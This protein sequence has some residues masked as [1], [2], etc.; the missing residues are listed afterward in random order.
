MKKKLPLLLI[1]CLISAISFAQ[2]SVGQTSDF[3][4]GT[5][6]GWRHQNSNPN[7]PVNITTD[8]PA[9]TDDNYVQ[10]TSSGANGAG[11]RFAIINT[12]A[13]WLGDYIAAGVVAISFDVRNP[14]SSDL[15]LRVAAN[16]VSFGQWISTSNAVVIPA[17]SDW[18]SVTI[19]IQ[20]SD[21]EKSPGGNP[22]LT[23]ADILSDVDQIRIVSNDGSDPTAFSSYLHKGDQVALEGDFDNITADDTLSDEDFFVQ[24]EGFTISPNP[25]KN[26]LNISLPQSLESAMINVYDV[27]GK[28]VYTGQI[29]SLKPSIDVSNWNSG[30]YLVRVSNDNVT[31]TKRF[32][33]Q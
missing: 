11:S 32:V 23:V 20:A 1:S 12:E 2:I 16:G 18:T 26:D 21:M 31:H 24:D 5:T 10:N 6:Q 30:V 15:Y 19:N 4:D 33:K 7:D 14:G 28:R 29:N 3:E 27:L 9:G 13:D 25:G 17:G 8:G 22:A